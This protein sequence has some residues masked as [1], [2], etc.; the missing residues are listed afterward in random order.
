MVTK[1]FG[2]LNLTPDSFSDGGK[3]NE[4][5][6]ALSQTKK[7]IEDGAD[8]I[9]IGAESTR[10][11]ATPITATQEWHRLEKILPEII[12]YTKKNHPQIE[13]SLDSRH[14]ETIFKALELGIDIINDVTGFEN[15][16]MIKLANASQKK[17]VVMHNL[18]IPADKSKVLPEDSSPT[19]ILI[20]W[21]KT[22]LNQLTK[23]GIKQPKII[24]DPGLGFGKTA[25][26]SIHIL[27][28]IE[29]L[30]A[31]EIPLLIGHSKKSFLDEMDFG[32]KKSREEK[33]ILLSK[34]LI[35]EGVNYLR[36]HDISA[37][38]NRKYF[39]L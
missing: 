21:I 37:N 1:F 4:V 9:D 15:I 32:E 13:I 39:E 17:I 35:D 38:K 5:D 10:P 16:E 19:E 33:T 8:I 31:L 12:N 2:I 18:G 11:G 29:K 34:K 7:L 23:S 36:V 20:S 28:N 26:Q 24:F 30:K 14:P 6:L 25:K 27:E 22:K 3:F